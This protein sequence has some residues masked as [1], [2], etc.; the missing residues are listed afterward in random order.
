[1]PGSILLKH[2][3]PDLSP[4]HKPMRTLSSIPLGFICMTARL[5]LTNGASSL[6]GTKEEAG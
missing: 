3:R 4:A 6:L 2:Q 1:M 5:A